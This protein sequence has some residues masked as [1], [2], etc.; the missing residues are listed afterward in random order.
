MAGVSAEPG[1]HNVAQAVRSWLLELQECVRAVDF[2][3]ARKLFDP[4][5]VSF[6][7]VAGIA[8]GLPALEEHQW[9]RVWPYIR[10]FT[11]DLESLVWDAEGDTA[12]AVAVWTS[13]G[14]DVGGQ[15]Y[16]R[17]GRATVVLRRQRGAWRAVH[18][19]FSLIPPATAS[20]S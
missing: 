13:S 17:P 15:P 20:R 3:R 10:D 2:E 9:R 4:E 7:T 12:W 14:F 5:V 11:F 8:R 1:E 6:G 19:H 16:H 18:T